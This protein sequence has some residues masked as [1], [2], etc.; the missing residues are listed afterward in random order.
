MRQLDGVDAAFLYTELKNSPMHVG[1]LAIYDPSVAPAPLSKNDITEHIVNRGQ[2]VPTMSEVLVEVPMN[3]D[4]P[5]WV[6]TRPFRPEDHIHHI[7]L[8][9]PGTWEQLCQMVAELHAHPLDR[10]RPLWEFYVIHGLDAVDGY[11]T[12]CFGLLSKIHHAI[13]DGAAGAQIGAVI[14]DLE[15][16]AGE[17]DDAS[18]DSTAVETAP[19]N[20]RLLMRAQINALRYPG[21]V[22]AGAREVLPRAGK[23]ML[24]VA[25]G[26][27]KTPLK[28]P[29]TRFNGVVTP[30][31]VF[32]AA[33]FKLSTLLAQK[34]P[35]AGV[36]LNDVALTICA[37]A[38]REFL[39]A[40]GEL[41]ER[42]LVAAVPVNL[43]DESEQGVGGNQ[44][45]NMAVSLRTDLADP[46]ERL[47]AISKATKE[48]KA[49]T[50]VLGGRTLNTLVG[51]APSALTGP[52][53][54][55]TGAAGLVKV[56]PP[57]FNCS[58]TNVPQSRVPL[59]FRGA[60][61]LSNFGVGPIM[62]GIGVFHIINS[63]CDELSIAFC[64]CEAMIPDPAAYAE[65]LRGA[66]EE[67]RSA[68]KKAA[69]SN[70]RGGARGKS[71]ARKTPG[72]RGRSRRERQ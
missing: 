48:S 39:E 43:R 27:L 64:S 14:H 66:E 53:S 4:H 11:P 2:R 36:T 52:V 59:Y 47:L 5:Y 37:G 10:S 33:R 35:F 57:S 65:L 20:A 15:A 8:P 71:A 46:V 44:V 55:L 18:S 25:R 45:T 19:G 17:A 1:G 26:E 42:P 32:D 7:D 21:R 3:L 30:D 58:I 61:M 70:H 28:V 54:R 63:Y 6:A 72:K 9:S 41:P 69:T 23:A 67:L 68:M 16:D 13:I 50:E 24:N 40:Q 31:R 56:T 22:L 51:L 49:F 12:G 34:K 60:P 62:N 38:L 29:R